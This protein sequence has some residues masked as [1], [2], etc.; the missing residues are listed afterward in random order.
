MKDRIIIGLML[1]LLL[2]VMGCKSN[3]QLNHSKKVTFSKSNC[4]RK[5]P[6]YSL[7]FDSKGHAHYKG[8]KNVSETGGHDF[9]IAK[10]ELGR[11]NG[12]LEGIDFSNLQESYNTNIRDLPSTTIVYGGK[13]ITYKGSRNVP[14]E[15]KALSAHL[16]N[17]LKDKN[18]I[19]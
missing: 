18:F 6:V 7:E 9:E 8:Y 11:L 5:C 15:L 2:S 14:R 16:E 1:T 4:F 12:I 17:I 3:T 13:K 19:H 10:D